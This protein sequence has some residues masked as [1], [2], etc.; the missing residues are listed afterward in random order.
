MPAFW[1]AAVFVGLTLRAGDNRLEVSRGADDSAVE[2]LVLGPEHATR[3]PW[4]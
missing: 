2:V 4:P 1:P 3:L